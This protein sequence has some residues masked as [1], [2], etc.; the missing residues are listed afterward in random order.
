M[1]KKEKK[2]A[3]VRIKEILDKC[4]IKLTVEACGCCSSPFVSFE[5]NGEVIL[6]DESD[7]NIKDNEVKV[8]E[9]RRIPKRS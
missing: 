4:G 8:D 7:C 2:E 1:T 6:S 9:L 5:Y 3:A